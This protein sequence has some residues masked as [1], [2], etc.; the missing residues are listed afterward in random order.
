M[1]WV[2]SYW[3]GPGIV[4]DWGRAWTLWALTVLGFQGLGSCGAWLGLVLLLITWDLVA[5][6]GLFV[7]EFKAGKVRTVEEL[8]TVISWLGLSC[9]ACSCLTPAVLLVRAQLVGG[10][11]A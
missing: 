6:R 2:G 9:S 10:C 11:A 7:L 8:M 3:K 1:S 5:G 4:F